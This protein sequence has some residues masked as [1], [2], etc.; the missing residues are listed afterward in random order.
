MKRVRYTGQI[1]ALLAAVVGAVSCAPPFPKEVLEKTDRNI[2]F[3]DLRENPEKYKGTW[4]MVGGIIVD[5]KSMKE[6]SYLEVLQKALDSRGRP[7]RTDATEGRFLVF[8]EK[9]LDP[10]VYPRGRAI[11]VVAEVAGKRVLPLGDIEYQY[12]LLN[13]KAIR[14]W[15][16]YTGPTFHFGIGVFHQF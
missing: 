10:A 16:P 7:L 12:P 6:G 2:S 8:S 4:V 11:S 14:L 1:I 3:R 9:F 13:A 5:A 15:E